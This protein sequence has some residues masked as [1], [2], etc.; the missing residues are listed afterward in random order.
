M[1]SGSCRCAA[2]RVPPQVPPQNHPMVLSAAICPD[3]PSLQGA[4]RI[5]G[6]TKPGAHTACTAHNA[7]CALYCARTSR[8]SC[9]AW[10]AQALVTLLPAV[11]VSGI[12]S[13]SRAVMNRAK[14]GE[15]QLFAEGFDFRV[16]CS[17]PSWRLYMPPGCLLSYRMAH[18]KSQ[19]HTQPSTDLVSTELQTQTQIRTHNFAFG[20]AKG[21][22]C[23]TAPNRSSSYVQRT[24]VCLVLVQKVTTKPR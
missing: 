8:C 14:G 5:R 10:R 7:H 2:I 21:F 23:T 13:I 9:G 1:H 4:T 3:C 19:L 6:S 15:L 11:V 22:A 16:R 17:R 24:E 12:P 18:R 20:P